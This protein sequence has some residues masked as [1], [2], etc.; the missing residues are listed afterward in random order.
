MALQPVLV[1]GRWQVRGS[2]TA[3]FR[4]VNPATRALL[5]D[6][7]PVSDEAV[8]EEALAA[9]KEAAVALR[10]VAPET[11]ARFLE[12]C[13][14]QVEA[15]TDALVEMAHI[16]TAFPKEPRLRSV[17]LP[18]T[19]AQLRQ[20]ARA[21]RERSFCR[22]TIDTQANIRSMHGPLGSPVAVFGP[23]NFPF[24]FNGI[25][26]GDFAAAVA[27]GNPVIGKGQ[28]ESPRHDAH[29]RR[30]RLRGR[31]GRW[32]PPGHGAADLSCP[33]RVG[34]EARRRTRC[35]APPASP[36]AAAPASS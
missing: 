23:N 14:E 10:S 34:A 13:A 27:A 6:S 20:A 16:E 26:G 33:R 30:G 11:V 8:V 2:E 32:P 17:E 24:A 36:A 35:S 31:Q 22:A 9:G 3:S 28:P 19:T 4:A 21:A 15:R 5:S 25:M 18:R 7:Y 12:L 29:P 1:G